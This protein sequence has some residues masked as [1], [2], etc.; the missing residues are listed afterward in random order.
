MLTEKDAM[1][2]EK[3]ALLSQIRHMAN[4]CTCPSYIT[5]TKL[6]YI[7]AILKGEK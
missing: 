2:K 6:N 7:L 1:Q 5:I 3:D 4:L